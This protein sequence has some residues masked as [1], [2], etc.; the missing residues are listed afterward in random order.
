MEIIKLKVDYNM[1]AKYSKPTATVVLL[2]TDRYLLIESK[3][4]GVSATISG[5]SQDDEEG[6]GF[7][8]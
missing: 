6:G 5:Y 3:S 2:E 7:T 1:K 4:V 8:Q